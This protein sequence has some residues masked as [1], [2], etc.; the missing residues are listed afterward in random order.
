MIKK[1]IIETEEQKRNREIVESIA[2]N[3]SSLA[4]AV[5]ALLNGPVKKQALIVLLSYSSGLSQERVK[6]VL[7]AM[8]N[9]EK[10]WLK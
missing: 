10:D 9:L 5:S 1:N 2:V 3:I 8:E 7:G 6:A 4:R